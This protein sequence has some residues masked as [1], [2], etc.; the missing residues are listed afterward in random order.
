MRIE[1]LVFV[2]YRDLFK[3]LVLCVGSMD[4][5]KYVL[6]KQMVVRTMHRLYMYHN[7]VVLCYYIIGIVSMHVRDNSIL[8][9]FHY[10]SIVQCPMCGQFL[11]LLNKY[12]NVKKFIKKLEE[13]LESCKQN[14]STP[15]N[16]CLIPPPRNCLIEEITYNDGAF[17]KNKKGE[18]CYC[19]VREVDTHILLCTV[20]IMYK[21]HVFYFS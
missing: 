13:D 21:N 16:T 15:N 17:V 19:R 18:I 12:N 7:V 5:K 14:R 6:T 10:C 4:F 1:G 20:N 8:T 3:V 11:T 9:C 2:K